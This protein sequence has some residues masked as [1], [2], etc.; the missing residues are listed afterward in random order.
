MR[1]G[2]FLLAARFPGGSDADALD[3]TVAAAVAAE[4]AGFDD[5][6]IAEHHFMGYGVVPSAV[7]LAGHVLGLTRRVHVGTAVSVLPNQHP[8]AL[9]EQAALLSLVSGG[10]F[11]LGVGRG[12]PW[13]DLEVFGTGLSR[14]E[15]GFPESLDLLLAWLRSERLGWDGKHFAFREVPVVPRARELPPVVVACTSP[16]TERVAAERGLPMLLGM[17]VGDDEKVAAL[18][19]HGNLYLPHVSAHLVQ[20]ADS[21][22]EAEATLMREMP[23]WLSPGL[24]GYVTVDDRPRPPRDDAS[25]V[26]R[27]CRIHPI[28][29]PADCVA[30]ITR[31]YRR[32][33]I[34]H[35][36]FLVEAAGTREATLANIA[37]IGAEV[38]P[39]LRTGAGALPPLKSGAEPPPPL[40]SGT[41]A[42]TGPGSG[43]EGRPGPGSSAEGRP[44][45]GDGEGPGPQGGP[46]P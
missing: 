11:R 28:G 24:D 40:G 6:W 3:R 27:L 19:R 13:R 14:F 16:G 17:H 38:L 1:F 5:V 29:T 18:A 15:D 30:A 37:R 10:R 26:R 39:R 4:D 42:P 44:R 7:T 31:T 9:A 33:N 12:G 45:A 32:T 8:V 34:R 23:R 2:V 36:I 35:M 41:E 20:V 25:Y 43:A 22:A 21:R 46:G